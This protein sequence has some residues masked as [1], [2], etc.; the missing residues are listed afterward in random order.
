MNDLETEAAS[1]RQLKNRKPT[2]ERRRQ[3][4][5]ALNSKF[6]GLQS[7]ALQVL[8]AWGDPDSAATLRKFLEEAFA[9]PYGWSIR[10]VAV[11]ALS[12]AVG[13]A[14]AEWVLD[15]YFELPDV[16]TKHETLP[17]VLALPPD[18]ARKRLVRELK[19]PN[20]MN[21]QAAVKA[22]GNIPYPA[23]ARPALRRP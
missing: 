1:L 13:E 15:L 12:S 9:R 20:W 18:A 19:S 7:V 2:P 6:E 10:K 21:R 3:L 8:G 11:N 17:L 5:Q 22:I 14:D 4:V 16:L 23:P